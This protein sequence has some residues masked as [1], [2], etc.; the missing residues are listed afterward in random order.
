M[1]SWTIDLNAIELDNIETKVSPAQLERRM[2]ELERKFNLV[3]NMKERIQ[4]FEKIQTLYTKVE[5]LAVEFESKLLALNQHRM[6]IIC[7]INPRNRT[8]LHGQTAHTCV[9][10]TCGSRLTKCPIC[11]E[12]I[13][14]L[15]TNYDS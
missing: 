3:M 10:D 9:C 7:C 6:C 14:R 15:V 13:E 4:Q 8:I 12:P 1:T 2:L 11:V 5:R